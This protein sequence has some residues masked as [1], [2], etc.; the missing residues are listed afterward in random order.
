VGT[1]DRQGRKQRFRLVTSTERHRRWPMPCGGRIAW[2]ALM[3]RSRFS[4]AHKAN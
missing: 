1:V 2:P 4:V 3:Q